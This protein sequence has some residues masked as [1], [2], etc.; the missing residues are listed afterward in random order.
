MTEKAQKI[1]QAFDDRYETIGP[2]DEDWQELCIA[3]TLRELVKQY[4]YNNFH[5]DGDHGIDVMNVKDI[6]GLIDEL[7]KL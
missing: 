6:L 7:E 1:V 2:F 5:I 4:A 3:A